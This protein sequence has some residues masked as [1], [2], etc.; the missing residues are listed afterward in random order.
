[1]FKQP[2][3]NRYLDDHLPGFIDAID[4]RPDASS[5]RSALSSL[6]VNAGFKCFAYVSMRGGG[7]VTGYSNYHEDWQRK[8]LARNYFAIDPVIS[9][10]RRTMRPTTWSIND[11]LSLDESGRRVFDEAAEFG[12]VSG[13]A[14]PVRGSFGRTA[15]LALASDNVDAAA[16]GVRDI[17]FAATA[18]TVMH[19]NLQRLAQTTQLAAAA[20]LSPREQ[21]C[22]MWASFGKTYS[23]TASML[24]ITEK[25][26]RFYLERAREKLGASNTTHA[27]RLA[28]ERGLL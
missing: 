28:T 6:A 3:V 12:I 17:A 15:I 7:D 20:L 5:I 10:A 25:T 22:L 26:V 18:V 23:E 9:H 24:G 2:S 21:T 14:V 27:V 13:I 19:V 8:Y 1:M 4:V 16:I 11:R